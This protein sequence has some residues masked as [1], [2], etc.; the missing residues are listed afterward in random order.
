MK[1]YGEPNHYNIAKYVGFLCPIA[2]GSLLLLHMCV[3]DVTRTHTEWTIDE[4]MSA[5]LKEIIK[6]IY[7]RLDSTQKIHKYSIPQKYSCILYCIRET[8]T[9]NKFTECVVHLL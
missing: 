8:N 9:Q 4:L 7:L 6:G 2:F 3:V 1:P 5:I